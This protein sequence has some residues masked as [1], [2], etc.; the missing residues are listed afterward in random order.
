MN[1]S[2]LAVKKPGSLRGSDD[3]HRATHP[4]VMKPAPLSFV[5]PVSEV[6]SYA[7][8]AKAELNMQT[9]IDY[10]KR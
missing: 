9:S 8:R 6:A 2:G 4:L 1:S 3:D 5:L 10:R 7:N